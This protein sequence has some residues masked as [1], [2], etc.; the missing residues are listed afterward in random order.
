MAFDLRV[1]IIK[2][3]FQNNTNDVAANQPPQLQRRSMC[4]AAGAPQTPA[5]NLKRCQN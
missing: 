3:P 5:G 1:P 2:H 4:S